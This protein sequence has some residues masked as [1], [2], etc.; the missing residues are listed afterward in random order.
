M[1][2]DIP[3]TISRAKFRS[4]VDPLLAELGTNAND[5]KSVTANGEGFELVVFDRDEGGN[6]IATERGIAEQ[7]VRVH[8][9]R[10]AAE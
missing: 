2:S 4:L 6:R 5:C 9:L 8:I 10:E 3:H 1:L 7:T